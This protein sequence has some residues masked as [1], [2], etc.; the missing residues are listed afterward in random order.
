M[1]ETEG[2]YHLHLLVADVQRSLHFY[3]STFG[4]HVDFW[5]GDDMVFVRMPNG[6]DLL[7]LNADPSSQSKVGDNGG[8][9]HFG[10]QLAPGVTID[11]AIEEIVRN[12]G[13]LERR[14]EHGPGQPYA[15][16]RDLDGYLFEI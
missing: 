8:L 12:G 3:E 15:Y 9:D 7:T 2:L 11:D 10:F 14:G 4:V 6:R 1:I 13:S 5:A 16:C